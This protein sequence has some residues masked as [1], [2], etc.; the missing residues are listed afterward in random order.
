MGEIDELPVENRRAILEQLIV[1]HRGSLYQVAVM[2]RAYRAAGVDA[3][4]VK[5]LADQVVAWQKKVDALSEVLAAL[6]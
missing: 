3:V 2:A 6:K 5:A 4:E 1:A